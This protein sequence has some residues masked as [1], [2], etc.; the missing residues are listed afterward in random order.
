MTGAGDS[1]D[2]PRKLSDTLPDLTMDLSDTASFHHDLGGTASVGLL[3]T[4]VSQR[5]HPGLDRAA[6]APAQTGTVYVL[7]RHR[8]H[9][10][11]GIVLARMPRACTTSMAKSWAARQVVARLRPWEPLDEAD[12]DGGWHTT[13]G[14]LVE[15]YALFRH[16]GGWYL[17]DVV[18][19]VP[20]PRIVTD[21]DAQAWAADVLTPDTPLSWERGP[22]TVSATTWYARSPTGRP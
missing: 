16:P 21:D 22:A 5:V 12:P 7:R 3:D 10:V 17:L 1:D 20:R 18:S 15:Q 8:Q 11:A 14:L 4:V 6:P 9:L 19:R 13:S 2:H